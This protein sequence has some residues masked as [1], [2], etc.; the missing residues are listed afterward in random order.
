MSR[1][2]R[3]SDDLFDLIRGRAENGDLVTYEWG[4]PDPVDGVYTPT[5]TAHADDNLISTWRTRAE[6][7][8]GRAAE[9]EAALAKCVPAIGGFLWLSNN[10]HNAASLRF[11]EFF[12]AAIG[13]AQTAYDEAS[14]PSSEPPEK[15]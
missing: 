6:V 12:D 14:R 9:L 11:K 5:F 2:I 13:D 1:L 3:A 4:E 8:E 10:L 15:S 7:A